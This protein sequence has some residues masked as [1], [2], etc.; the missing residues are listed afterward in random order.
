MNPLEDF[1]S[2]YGHRT[3]EA[4]M[5]EVFRNAA[6]VAGATAAMGAAITGVTYGARKIMDAATKGRDFNNMLAFNPD[7]KG[8]QKHNPQMFNQMYSSL[9]SM[10]PQFAK[11][12]LVAGTYMRRMSESPESAGGILTDSSSLRSHAP[13]LLD[14]TRDQAIGAAS[15][16]I[17]ANMFKPED[18]LAK[19]KQEHEE[20]K[21]RDG[22]DKLR[23]VDPLARLKQQVEERKLRDAL[24]PLELERRDRQRVMALQDTQR[25]Y[26]DP[27]RGLPW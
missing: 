10:N 25:A 5:G 13:T 6:A 27:K 22:L 17:S 1:L 19:L 15:G 16:H 11:D 12:P 18:P 24:H 23:A 26:R 3:K 20:A 2:E 9:R 7:L 14:R 21:L 4:G 8:Y